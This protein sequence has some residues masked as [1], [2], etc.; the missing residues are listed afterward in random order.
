MAQN[1]HLKYQT[2]PNGWLNTQY[3]IQTSRKMDADVEARKWFLE[4]LPDG[5]AEWKVGGVSAYQFW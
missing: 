2:I 5:I 4:G 3:A 1:G